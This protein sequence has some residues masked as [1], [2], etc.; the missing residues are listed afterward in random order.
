MP[1]A[2]RL[3]AGIDRDGAQRATVTIRLVD[4]RGNPTMT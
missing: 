4:E 2:A 1:E 3:R